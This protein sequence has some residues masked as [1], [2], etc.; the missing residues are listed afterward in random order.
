MRNEIDIRRKNRSLTK[1]TRIFFLPIRPKETVANFFRNR[2]GRILY[3]FVPLN[4]I[5]LQI[6]KGKK[7]LTKKIRFYPVVYDQFSS[8]TIS[9]EC[10]RDWWYLIHSLFS[11]EMQLFLRTDAQSS[12]SRQ[13]ERT[14]RMADGG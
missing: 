7:T 14:T 11:I 2:F 5:Y 1:L 13:N 8:K 6:I 12:K 3:G 9:I 4:F 10:H